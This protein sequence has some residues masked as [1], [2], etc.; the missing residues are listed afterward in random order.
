MPR[1]IPLQMNESEGPKYVILLLKLFG[2]LS[3]E[4]S[5]QRICVSYMELILFLS[6]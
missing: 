1:N 5:F 4:G 2:K 3:G 6:R